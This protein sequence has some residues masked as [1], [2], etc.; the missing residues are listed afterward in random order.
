MKCVCVLLST[1][2]GDKYLQEQL[3][4]LYRQEGV[5]LLILARDDGSS[6]QTLSL[7]RRNAETHSFLRF[8]AGDNV[9]VVHSF[10]DL[11]ANAP[12][13][14]YYAFCDQDDVWDPDKLA[15]AVAML[16]KQNNTKPAMYYSNL[17][18]VDANLQFHRNS[19]AA[20]HT[21]PDKYCTLV[22]VAPTGCTMVFNQAARQM[23]IGRIPQKCTMH[24][25]WLNMVCAFWGSVVY[26]FQPHISYRQHGD[27]VIGTYLDRITARIIIDRIVRL[28]DRGKQPRYENAKNF[29]AQYQDLLAGEDLH[30]VEKMVHY[31]DSLHAKLDLLF[32]R[33]IHGKNITRDLVYRLLIILGIA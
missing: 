25:I 32:D 4:S 33:R 5:E 20:P 15:C 29:L 21:L 17:R 27:N 28:F 7:L 12:L 9:G 24:D 10:F 14:D 31:K 2:N 23:T 30:A 6:D 8:Y 11:L 26:D 13:A 18:I 19:H 1:Y 22:D 16:E 3:D